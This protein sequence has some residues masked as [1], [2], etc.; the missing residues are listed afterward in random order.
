MS[1][2]VWDKVLFKY[3]PWSSEPAYD[4]EGVIEKAPKDLRKWYSVEWEWFWIRIDLIEIDDV[5]IEA[6]SDC[7]NNTG[8]YKVLMEDLKLVK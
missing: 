4:I 5:D 3:K 1:F 8:L 2:K 7:K 6:T